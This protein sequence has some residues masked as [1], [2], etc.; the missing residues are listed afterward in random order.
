MPVKVLEGLKWGEIW[1]ERGAWILCPCISHDLP[2]I[3]Q[4]KVQCFYGTGGDLFIGKDYLTSLYLHGQKVFS[5]CARMI[6]YLICKPYGM[7]FHATDVKN[8]LFKPVPIASY[9]IPE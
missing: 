7:K 9:A 2:W 5:R 1:L 3:F 8:W 6:E 4:D